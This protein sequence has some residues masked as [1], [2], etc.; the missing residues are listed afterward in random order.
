MTY[1][2]A[3]VLLTCAAS[4]AA[5]ASPAPAKPRA[6]RGG[7]T[8][9]VLA[10]PSWLNGA[11]GGVSRDE[12]ETGCRAIQRNAA[13]R[14]SDPWIGTVGVRSLLGQS[15]EAGMGLCVPNPLP[16]EDSRATSLDGARDVGV[17]LWLKLDF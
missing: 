13:L 11:F 15:C 3:L 12:C 6:P 17:G 4:L 1:L 7:D 2:K 10:S 14:P 16:S 8:G 5:C 9:V